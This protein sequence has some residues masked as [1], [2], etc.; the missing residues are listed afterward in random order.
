MA[1]AAGTVS[2]MGLGPRLKG[3]DEMPVRRRTLRQR[4]FS[5]R[6]LVHAS[7]PLGWAWLIAK[8]VVVIFALWGIGR[9]T[10]FVH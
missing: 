6:S 2:V 1:F 9:L 7:I 5:L 4:Y 10:G 8:W 3:L